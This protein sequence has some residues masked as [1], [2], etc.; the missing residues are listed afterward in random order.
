MTIRVRMLTIVAFLTCVLLA[1]GEKSYGLPSLPGVP[2]VP[3]P[4]QAAKGIVSNELLKQFGTWFNMNRPVY[5]SGNDVLSTVATLPG[6]PFHPASQAVVQTLFQHA[7][8]GVLQLPAGDYNV[9]VVTYCMG[10]NNQ[11]PWRN[12][13]LLS[14]LRGAWSD[15]AVALNYRAYGSRFTPPQVQML[16]WSLQAGMAYD[17]MSPTSRQIVDTLLPEYKGRLQEDFYD[18]ARDEWNSISSKVPGAPNFENALGQLGDVGKSIVELREARDQIVANAN[19]FNALVAQFSHLGNVRPQ[20]AIGATPWS[21][22]HPGVYARLRTKGTLLTPGVVQIRV[23]AQAAARAS[24]V[25]STQLHGLGGQLA[26]DFGFPFTNWAGFF[27][28]FTQPL[29]W[30][31]EPG[32]APDPGQSDG[33]PDGGQPNGWTFYGGSWHRSGGNGGSNQGSNNGNNNNDD[34]GG[35]GGG[36]NQGSTAPNGGNSNNDQD[37][38]S[39]YPCDPPGNVF[40]VEKGALLSSGSSAM[41]IGR[42]KGHGVVCLLLRPF[43]PMA[44]L[45]WPDRGTGQVDDGSVGYNL[46]GAS[47]P[48]NLVVLAHYTYATTST[49]TQPYVKKR[50]TAVIEY[51][52]VSG[53]CPELNQALQLHPVMVQLGQPISNWL[54]GAELENRMC[55]AGMLGTAIQVHTWVVDGDTI[56]Q[57]SLNHPVDPQNFLYQDAWNHM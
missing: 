54:S 47:G 39:S 46:P 29:S 31:P 40:G 11:G 37:D 26:F 30:T 8:S 23:T 43:V 33:G 24:E 6:G 53:F 9:A 5:V 27:N 3:N 1:G 36:S 19:D 10:H 22:I 4:G 48:G 56:N 16:S 28:G 51:S 14:P 50:V 42:G 32:N 17:E 15:V 41:S 34:S 2:S 25:A 7:R 45:G 12:K 35:G 21:V 38:D 44:A 13:F 20:D 52:D 18:R 57:F 55:I 49:I